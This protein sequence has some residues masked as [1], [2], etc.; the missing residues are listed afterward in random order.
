M[1]TNKEGKVFEGDFQNS[2]KKYN[3]WVKRIKDTYYMNSQ[4]NKPSSTNTYDY[5]MFDD[6]QGK[7]WA[8]ELKSTVY[9]SIGFQLTPDEP[10]AMIKAHQIKGLMDAK[11]GF[12][13][14]QAGF[15]LQYR[16]TEMVY[17]IEID[18]FLRF[19]AENDRKSITPLNIMQYNGRIITSKKLRTHYLLNINDITMSK[20]L[21]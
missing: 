4:V 12:K 3:Y 7:L 1:P 9:K 6:K 20:N 2:C 15:L 19:V 16:D 18:D 8:L 14:V 10:V 21:E 11:K 5:L 17:Y 13:N